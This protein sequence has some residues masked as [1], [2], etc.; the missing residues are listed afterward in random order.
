MESYLIYIA[1]IENVSIE[2]NSKDYKKYF[3]LSKAKIK[4][5]LYNAYD[6][7]LRN[8]YEIVVNNKALDNVKNY[9]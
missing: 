1:K 5:N 4:N 8:K 7:Y 3:N 9:F 2:Y 6:A